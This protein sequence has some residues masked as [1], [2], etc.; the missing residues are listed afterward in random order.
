MSHEFET[1]AYRQLLISDAQSVGVDLAESNIF[2][3]GELDPL[4]HY[5]HFTTAAMRFYSD[6]EPIFC[7]WFDNEDDLNLYKIVG[8]FTECATV[9]FRI[10]PKSFFKRLFRQWVAM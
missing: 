4:V 2:K 9:K 5:A 8:Q 6:R 7:V 10:R 3:I 1:Y